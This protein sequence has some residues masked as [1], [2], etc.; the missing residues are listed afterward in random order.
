MAIISPACDVPEFRQLSH[1]TRRMLERPFDCRWLIIAWIGLVPSWLQGG[2]KVDYVQDVKPLLKHCHACH[3]AL[4]QQSGLRVDTAAGIRRGGESGSAI[5]PGRSAESLLIHALTGTNGATRMPPADAAAPLTEKSIDKIRDWIDQGAEAPPE[6]EPAGP[7]QHWAFR[8][9]NRPPIPAVRQLD[10][11]KNPIDRFVLAEL[12]RRGLQ[13]APE[14]A[15]HVLLRRVYLDLIGL[16]PAPD[17][18]HAFLVDESQDAYEKVVARLLDSPQYGER[19]GRHWMDVWRYSDWAGYGAEIRE[20]QY[21]IWRW[22]DWIIESLNNDKPYDQM[23]LEMVAGDEIA[24]T[25][26]GVLR[27]T[28]FLGRNWFKFNRN[29]WLDNTIEHC[30]KAFLGLTFNCARCHDHK[31]DPISQA[32]YF[33]LRAIFEP[34]DVRYDRVAGQTDVEKD[35]IAR[36][37]DKRVDDPTFVFIAGNE[38]TPDKDHPQRPSLPEFFGVCYSPTPIALPVESYYP[39][40]T[41]S[42]AE[43]AR[44]QLTAKVSAAELAIQKGKADLADVQAAGSKDGPSAADPATTKMPLEQA[45]VNSQKDLNLAAKKL[46]AAKSELES[47]DRR[48]AAERVRFGMAVEADPKVLA[49]A[50]SRAEHLAAI[51]MA[52]VEVVESEKTLDAAK[53]AEKPGD[54][55]SKKNI[56]DAQAKVDAARKKLEAARVELPPDSD[57]YAPLGE[58]H[59]SNSTGRRL[60]LARWLTSPGNPL[61]ARVAINHLWLRHFGRPIVPTMFDFGLNGRPPSHPELL[62]WLAA[63][64]MAN[65]WHMKHIHRLLVLSATYR[66]ASSVDEFSVAPSQQQ[67]R[68]PDNRFLWRMN[69]RRLEAEIVRDSLLSVAGSLDAAIGG[70]EKDQNQGQIV[71]RRSIYFRHAKEKE[72]VFTKLFDGPGVSECYQR[73]ESIVPQQALALANSPLAKNQSRLLAKQLSRDYP[74]NQADEFVT[75]AFE[76]VLTRSPTPYEL[77]TCREFLLSQAKLFAE[78]NRLTTTSVGEPGTVPAATEPAQRAR[79][80]LVHVLVNHHDFVTVR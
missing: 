46:G 19:W 25:D 2:E 47:F 50:A 1:Q 14:A 73:D 6:I 72:M 51:A 54:A 38:Q 15:K 33:Q 4:R 9:P 27:A 13:H 69:P 49:R 56:A 31:Y 77:T 42:R 11:V 43:E 78:P 48:L 8:P 71:P 65:E 64:F 24:P 80:N 59:P 37:F 35:G 23:I 34:Y 5:V 16:P 55:K 39:A 70:P 66:Q 61:T 45:L 63:E 44:S 52:E 32:E 28:G 18:L 30:G 62:D 29:V 76:R 26:A 57:K 20:S 12:E 67:S 68:D 36:V 74:E 41:A 79:E 21:H 17:E 53:Q 58:I 10:W 7:G 22:R 40:I 3:G 60:A 75:A